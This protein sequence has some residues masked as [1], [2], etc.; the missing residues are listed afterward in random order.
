MLGWRYPRDHRRRLRQHRRCRARRARLSGVRTAP[1]KQCRPCST[2]WPSTAQGRSPP[3]DYLVIRESSAP[4]SARP[5]PH[6]QLRSSGGHACRYVI[7]GSFV[8]RRRA[9]DR[10]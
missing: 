8:A 1:S 6:P 5:Q 10:A 7:L 3:A 4:A 9:I 2:R